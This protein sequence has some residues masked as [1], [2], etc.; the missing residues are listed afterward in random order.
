[1]LIPA[2][3]PAIVAAFPLHSAS[4]CSDSASVPSL[5]CHAT[6]RFLD[7]D[8]DTK[9]R[10]VIDINL[11]AALHGV[12]LAA[13]AMSSKDRKPGDGKSR[14]GTIMVVASAGGV[15][16]IPGTPVYAGAKSALVHFV[17]SIEGQL[18]DRGIRIVALCPQVSRGRDMKLRRCV[19]TDLLQTTV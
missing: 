7:D 16:P 3:I 15:F 19:T 12:H 13:R 14:G 10:R 6:G 9:W 1:M 18:K 8:D 11:T 4:L 17:R 5:H 2:S